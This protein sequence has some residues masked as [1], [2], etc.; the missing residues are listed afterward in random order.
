MQ[1]ST[2]LPILAL[3]ATSTPAL[4]RTSH[5]FAA[6]AHRRHIAKQQARAQ[7]RIE[8]AVLIREAQEES[9]RDM[10]RDLVEKSRKRSVK[11]RGGGKCRAK[12]ASTTDSASSTSTEAA[13]AAPSS[14]A[15]PSVTDSASV[16][17]S[18]SSSADAESASEPA[19]PIGNNQYYAT[20]AAAQTSSTPAS[21]AATSTASAV[22]ASTSAATSSGS[23]SNLT[24]N[25][26]K[27][28]IAGGDAYD[29]IKDHIGWWYDW[30]A[31]P[32]GHS[33]KPIAV[34]MLWGA[35]SVDGTD[36]SR[37][38][39]F[40]AITQ[41]PQ[42]IIGFEEPDCS[43]QGSANIDVSTAVSVWD[44]VIGPW[45]SK[46]SLLISPSMCHQKAEEYIKW[47]SAFN[48]QISVP[49]D[50]VNLHTNKNTVEGV[51]EDLDYYWS[52]YKKPMWVTEF[53]CVDDST[54]FVPC[55]DQNQINGF[56][57]DVVALFESD[58]RV[59]A[60]AYSNGEGLGDVWPMVVNGGL[61][62]SG[63]TYINAVSKYH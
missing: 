43:T 57:N 29:Q 41:T 32:S 49:F 6:G 15:D 54:G 14:S 9:A 19:S 47:L 44:S 45:K 60:Y 50:V 33:G 21:A 4:S 25:G 55:T 46:G 26:I 56:I 37:L 24:P 20:S 58:D 36:A 35:G 59:Y 17:E 5:P 30:N 40:K 42:Y 48:S 63:Q 53:A 38:A 31:V 7:E 12:T 13:I 23:S 51:K 10:P 22:A 3:L 62:Q 61:T 8:N 16:T 39:A 52:V 28:G 1:L 27:A 34:D 11:R 18:S 2:L